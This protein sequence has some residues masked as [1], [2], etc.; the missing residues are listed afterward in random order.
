[1]SRSTCE[2]RGI[3]L[4]ASSGPGVRPSPECSVWSASL[5]NKLQGSTN[6][7][8]VRLELPACVYSVYTWQSL[9]AWVCVDEA[10]C[11]LTLS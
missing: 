6:A 3:R 9:T 8:H 10:R 4:L 7:D 11:I 2:A 5:S 1:M